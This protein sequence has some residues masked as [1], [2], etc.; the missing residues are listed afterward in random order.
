MRSMTRLGGVALVACTVALPAVAHA[1]N[2]CSS[3]WNLPA[4]GSWAEWKGMGKDAQSVTRIAVIDQEQ[5]NGKPYYRLE[6][7]S[8]E[9]QGVFQMVV[10][11]L[12]QFDQVDE[13]VMQQDGKPPMKMSGQMLAMMRSRIPQ[14]K[15][16]LGDIASRCGEM[17]VVGTE[18]VTVPAGTFKTTHLKNAD[19]DEV[20]ATKDVPF[21]MVKYNG[22]DA[23]M[24]LTGTGKD[25]KTAIV[26]TP[27]EMGMPGMGG[28]K[29]KN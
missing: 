18:T 16:G 11:S 5:R 17:K 10:P 4:A 13:M 28:G 8:S 14:G 21:N 24:E 25:A 6:M 29:P 3:D 2:P 27:Q 20:W 12:W 7:A 9:A 1:Q 22:K 19:G 23:H 15:N 26:G